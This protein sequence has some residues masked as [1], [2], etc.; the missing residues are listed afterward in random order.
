M[1]NPSNLKKKKRFLLLLLADLF[2]NLYVLFFP[3]AIVRHD[4]VNMLKLISRSD[5]MKENSLEKHRD[6]WI[7]DF[8]KRAT[9]SNVAIRMLVRAELKRS[10]VDD[11]ELIEDIVGTKMKPGN[12][13]SLLRHFDVC[14]PT[15]ESVQLNPTAPEFCPKKKWEPSSSD[16]YQPNGACLFPSFL[17]SENQEVTQRWG[18]DNLEDIVVQIYFLPE[19]PHGFFHR[20]YLIWLNIISH[21]FYFL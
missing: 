19:I 8:E 9:L 11:D 17:H 12:L 10:G 18:Q 3:Q 2:P 16:V 15:K 20:Y 6:K 21:T 5:L 1:K 7:K 13:I 14:L 4:L